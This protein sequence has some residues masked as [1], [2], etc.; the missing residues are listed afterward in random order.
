MWAG[1]VGFYE[2]E[3]FQK[4]TKELAQSVSEQTQRGAFSLVGGGNT[5][6]AL[7]EFG[8][9]DEISFV[10][11]GGGAMLKFIVEGTLPGIQALEQRNRK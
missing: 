11:T 1:P 3:E 10:S 4:G 5:V 9:L 7:E 6:D 2:K 8:L